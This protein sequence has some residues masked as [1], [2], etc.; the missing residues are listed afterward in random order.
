[1]TAP[2]LV[3]PARNPITDPTSDPTTSDTPTQAGG[4]SA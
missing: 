1:V 2:S 3:H 4:I